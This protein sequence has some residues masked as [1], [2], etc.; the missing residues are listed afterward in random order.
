MRE[1][2]LKIIANREELL[3][4]AQDALT[5]CPDK[6]PLPELECALLTTEDGMLTVAGGNLQV[7]L[8]R[9]IPV[10]IREEGTVIVNAQLLVDMLRH[11]T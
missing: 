4:A 8:E 2:T 6:S 5:V 11:L 1:A 7:A 9:R 10:Q 3:S